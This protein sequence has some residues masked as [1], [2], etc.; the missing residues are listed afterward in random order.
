MAEKDKFVTAITD[1]AMQR[2][3]YTGGGWELTPYQFAVSSKDVLNGITIYDDQGEVTDEAKIALTEMNSNDLNKD[4]HIWCQFPFSSLIQDQTVKNTLQHHLVIPGN[5]SSVERDIKTI[6]FIYTPHDGEPFL[7]AVAVAPEVIVY[8]PNVTQSFF[9]NFTVTNNFNTND[10]TFTV[11]YTYPQAID[12]HNND[13]NAHSNFVSRDGTRDITGTL[14]YSGEREFTS[15]Y[16][17]VSKKYV[18][19]LIRVLKAQNNLR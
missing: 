11:D 7:Y 13:V 1:E 14:R 3:C 15:D 5:A 10:V 8:E 17:L 16:Q 18:D 9:F 2:I 6:Y 4:T 12:D 19:E